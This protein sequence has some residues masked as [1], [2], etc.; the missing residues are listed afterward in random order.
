MSGTSGWC[1]SGVAAVVAAT[2]MAAGLG[3]CGSS[4]ADAGPGSVSASRTSK[5]PPVHAVGGVRPVTVYSPPSYH[6]GTAMPLVILLHSYRSNGRSI[7]DFFKLR[8]LAAKRGF[9]YATPNGT[10]DIS[11]DQFWNA[12]DACCDL[13]GSGVDDSGYLAS[14]IRDAESRYSIDAKRVYVV[15]HSNGGFMAYRMACDHADVVAAI[16]S[17]AGAMYNDATECSPSQAVSVLE[18]HG[19]ADDVVPYEGGDILGH[20]VPSARTSVGDWAEFDGCD[21][22]FEPEQPTHLVQSSNAKSKIRVTT[23]SRGCR[24]RTEVQLWTIPGGGH[25]PEFAENLAPAL[26]DF[27]LAHPRQ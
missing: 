25:V 24:D 2:L 3:A 1:R 5:T 13:H 8:P 20:P 11:G 23:Y 18:V 26:I 10:T 15:G 16:V 19:V 6:T 4:G 27:L 17:V 9:L 22:A 12:T 7:D 14:V 21:S